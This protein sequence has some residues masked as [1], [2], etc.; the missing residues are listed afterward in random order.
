MKVLLLTPTF[1]PHLTGNAVTV[2]RIAREMEEGGIDCRVLDLSIVAEGELMRAAQEFSP[3]LIHGFHALKSGGMGLVIKD[4]LNIP[5]VLTLTGTDLYVDLK[6]P[7]KRERILRILRQADRLTVFNAGARQ[8]LLRQNIAPG[9]ISVIH[10]SVFL[11]EGRTRNFRRELHIGPK[12]RVFL[13]AGGIRR[14]KNI[15]YAFPVLERVRRD[16]P[17]LCL[18]IAGPVLEEDEFIRLS[19]YRKGRAWIRFLGEI[20]RKEIPS[21]FRCADIVLNTSISESEANTVMEALS[22]GKAVVGRR[23][24]GNAS[25]LTEDTGFLFRNREEL[26]KQILRVLRN[27]EE[28]RG[29]GRRARRYISAVFCRD[30]EQMEYLRLYRLTAGENGDP[31]K[32]DLSVN[33]GD[34]L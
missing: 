3:D 25:L 10:Q 2:G 4:L 27:K 17:D 13:L 23:I 32:R 9:K 20:P 30:K 8:R 6:V 24:C 34:F 26:Y 19:R 7:E 31:T 12:T 5:L 14:V 21:L 15:G 11:P 16:F 29:I 28:T 1:F 18:W 33:Q 22:L